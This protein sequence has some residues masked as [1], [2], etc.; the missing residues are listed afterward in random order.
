MKNKKANHAVATY[1]DRGKKDLKHV[2]TEKEALRLAEVGL[3]K[4]ADHPFKLDVFRQV[5]QGH[6]DQVAADKNCGRSEL[7]RDLQLPDV[8]TANETLKKLLRLLRT[9]G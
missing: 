6:L 4:H 1:Q 2:Y 8:C 9:L 3:L 5:V 7:L